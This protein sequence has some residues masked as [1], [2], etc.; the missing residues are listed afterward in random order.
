MADIAGPELYSALSTF[1]GSDTARLRAAFDQLRLALRWAA[2]LSD[3]ELAAELNL[4][5]AMEC[6]VM[7]GARTA[8][9]AAMRV[10]GS[11]ASHELRPGETQAPL[12]RIGETLDGSASK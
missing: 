3:A 11:I 5:E 1:V 10:G 4:L 2:H 12:S 6:R 8:Q 7:A 9:D